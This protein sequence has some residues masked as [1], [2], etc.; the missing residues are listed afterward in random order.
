M[1]YETQ[2]VIFA[3]ACKHDDYYNNIGRCGLQLRHAKMESVSV[4]VKGL[5]TRK[6]YQEIS[7]ELK[8][9]YPSIPSGLSIRSVR[10]T[11]SNNMLI[12]C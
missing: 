12:V 8:Q 10:R 2:K 3:C 6:T 9:L 7:D 11:I 4:D 1:F 5:A